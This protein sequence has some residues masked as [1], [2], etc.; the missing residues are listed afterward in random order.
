MNFGTAR[1]NK[2]DLGRRV[3][4]DTEWNAQSVDWRRELQDELLDAYSYADLCPDEDFK[5]R[6]QLFCRDTWT[7]LEDMGE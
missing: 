5:K 6:V 4:K 3:H 7:E 1:Q 2:F